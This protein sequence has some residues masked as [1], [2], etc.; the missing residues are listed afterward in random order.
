MMTK[1]I[2]KPRTVEAGAGWHIEY[3]PETRDYS[4]YVGAEYI[5]SRD[6]KGEAVD[7]VNDWSFEQVRRAA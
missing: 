2:K 3:D 7:L 4:A 6:S 5:G 1:R